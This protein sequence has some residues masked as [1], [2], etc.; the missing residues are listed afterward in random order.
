[1]RSTYFKRAVDIFESV[2]RGSKKS[3]EE[4][5]RRRSLRSAGFRRLPRPV[6]R[7]HH[8]AFSLLEGHHRMQI[9]CDICGGA[10]QR[11]CRIYNRCKSRWKV[12]GLAC[13]E[14]G[15]DTI[16]DGADIP[17]Q[18]ALAILEEGGRDSGFAALY[19]PCRVIKNKKCRRRLV[20]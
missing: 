20:L 6:R 12:Q 10:V 13:R 14:H 9:L 3:R 11:V 8:R 15:R 16:L 5:G 1:M 4:R 2:S 19:Q 17:A 18:R 7:G